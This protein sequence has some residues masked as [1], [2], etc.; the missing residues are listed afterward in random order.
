MSLVPIKLWTSVSVGIGVATLLSGCVHFKSEPISASQNASDFEART[1]G[2]PQL[3][4]F[5]ARNI[6]EE[7]QPS[8]PSS[9]DVTKLVL[10]AFFYHPDL[11]VARAKWAVAKAGKRIAGERPNPTVSVSPAYDTTT[12]IPSP[13]IVTAS[14]DIPIETAGKRGYRVEQAM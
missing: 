4:E 7:A 3:K 6:T 12:S 2:N 14:L 9:W 5:I 13:W 11:D 1:L 8:P 10:A